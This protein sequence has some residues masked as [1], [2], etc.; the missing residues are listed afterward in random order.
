MFSKSCSVLGDAFPYGMGIVLGMAFWDILRRVSGKS[1]GY[2]RARGVEIGKRF[3]CWILIWLRGKFQGHDEFYSV[4]FFNPKNY[5]ILW[6]VY[7]NH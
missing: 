5:M 3:M 2:F 1:Q 4:R 6:C 7:S